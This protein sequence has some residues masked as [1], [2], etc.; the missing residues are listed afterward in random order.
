MHLQK[1][2]PDF[3]AMKMLR[4]L[5]FALLLA[6]CEKDYTPDQALTR[7]FR[8]QPVVNALLCPDSV[9]HVALHW[10]KPTDS[11]QPFQVVETASIELKENGIPIFTGKIVSG[12]VRIDYYPAAGKTYSIEINID[13][14]PTV[15]ATTYVPFNSSLQAS[16]RQNSYANSHQYG[17]VDITSLTVDT[18]IRALWL[19]MSY[20][21]DSGKTK[22][23]RELFTNCPFMDQV[24]AMRDGSDADLKESNMTFD[25]NF[26]RIPRAHFSSVIPF[27]FS[28]MI[29]LEEVIWDD[30]DQEPEYMYV[31]EIS[32]YLLTPG[33]D[34]DRYMRSA[35]KMAQIMAFG[36]PVQEGTQM[37][38]SNIENGL[39]IFAGYNMLRI[40]MPL[41][42]PLK[43]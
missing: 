9:I 39:G 23:P 34:Y 13:G 4:I 41:D 18:Q 12:S 20:A 19:S 5:A 25:Y 2:Q 37:V 32:A 8:R 16:C 10:S 40:A 31:T 26:L 28:G 36:S 17:L 15:S 33:D 35:Y 7:S 30:Y 1:Y 22:N 38:Y 6:A 3:I 27:T 29:F 21:Y 11:K 43:P 42:N 24:N 14:E